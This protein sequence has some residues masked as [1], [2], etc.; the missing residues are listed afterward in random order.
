[1]DRPPVDDLVKLIEA[2]RGNLSDVA[3]KLGRSRSTVQSWVDNSTNA[4]RAL[5][6]ARE[7][8]VDVAE[9]VVY[10][11]AAEETLQAAFYILNND[12]K[13]RARGWGVQRFEHMGADGGAI[14]HEVRVR[15]ADDL[16]RPDATT[17][18]ADASGDPE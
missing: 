4:T 1:M 8:R 6:D 13:A 10:K 12:P 3:R 11:A 9:T 2:S 18:N 15:I 17:A 5:D 7:T 16:H 14:V